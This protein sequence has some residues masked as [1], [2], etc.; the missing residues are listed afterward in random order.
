MP[1]GNK[2]SVFI[3]IRWIGPASLTL[4]SASMTLLESGIDIFWQES[5]VCV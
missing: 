5:L 1:F 2:L 4:S 3:G